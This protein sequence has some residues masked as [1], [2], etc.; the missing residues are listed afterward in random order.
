MAVVGDRTLWRPPGKPGEHYVPVVN[1]AGAYCDVPPRPDLGPGRIIQ[2]L[3]GIR[4][5][6]HWMAP[7]DFIHSTEERDIRNPVTGCSWTKNNIF[8]EWHA[9]VGL[10]DGSPRVLPRMME[11]HRFLEACVWPCGTPLDIK[12]TDKQARLRAA[13]RDRVRILR[14]LVPLV[15]GLFLVLEAGLGS[16]W[17]AGD[18]AARVT[19]RVR[20]A[21]RGAYRHTTHSAQGRPR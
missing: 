7:V 18:S 5:G 14:A 8:N 9:T 17:P 16:G 3:S 2:L 19:C 13:H 20:I 6:I 10:Q 12:Y 21:L 11:S 4:T 15:I 1:D